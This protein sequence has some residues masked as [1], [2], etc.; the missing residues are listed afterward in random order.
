MTLLGTD[1]DDEMRGRVFAVLQ[2]LIRVVLVLALAAVPFVVAQV[3]EHTIPIGSGS[4]TVDGT[5][6]VLIAGGLLAL[7]AGLL[8]YRK[9]DD[10]EQV[11]DLGRRQDVAA[12]R[13]VG[14]AAACAAAGCSSRSRAA[15]GRASRP[16]SRCSP[17]PC[18]P[19]G[20]DRHR[21]ARAGRHRGRRSGSA[22]L[23]LHHRR[24]AL[25]A[26]RG[27]AVRRRPGAPRRHRDPA[28]AERGAGRADRPLRRLVAGL[29]GRG[30]RPVHRR[31]PPAVA[32]GDRRICARPHR[33]A[34]PA[35][36]RRVWPGP[37]GGGG[38]GGTSSRPSRWRSTSGCA[39]RSG[40]WPRPSR[41]ATW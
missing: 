33:S 17:M 3:G 26:R 31:H 39:R 1:V 18:A 8:A 38:R 6:I 13:L 10:R 5:R 29:S 41:A 23:L 24:A 40:C 4:Y 7:A 15:R 21:H 28:G 34:R 9:M 22:Q 19:G 32:V 36:R 20:H 25:A 30:P 11:V 14:A 2:S 16:R 12:R 37:R 35:G 27:A